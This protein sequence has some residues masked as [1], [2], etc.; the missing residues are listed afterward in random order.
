MT[1]PCLCGGRQTGVLQWD[2]TEKLLT[3]W[4]CNRCGI[5]YVLNWSATLAVYHAARKAV[6]VTA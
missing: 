5:V 4:T 1:R 3:H 6:T 2:V